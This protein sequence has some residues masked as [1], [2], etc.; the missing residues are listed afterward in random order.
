[1]Y[2][3]LT[4]RETLVIST[5]KDSTNSFIPRIVGGLCLDIQKAKGSNPLYRKDIG[6]EHTLVEFLTSKLNTWNKIT[7]TT[8]S[9]PKSDLSH[10]GPKPSEASSSGRLHFDLL[11]KKNKSQSIFFV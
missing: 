6:F 1:M 3:K 5:F 8:K 11:I 4:F 2:D 7:N 9:S 10:E